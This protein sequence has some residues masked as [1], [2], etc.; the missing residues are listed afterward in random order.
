LASTGLHTLQGISLLMLPAAT[1][2]FA[3]TVP[4][5]LPLTTGLSSTACWLMVSGVRATGRTVR[6]QQ[7]QQQQQQL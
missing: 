4:T 1:S 6:Q 5:G 3:V 2:S 7:Y